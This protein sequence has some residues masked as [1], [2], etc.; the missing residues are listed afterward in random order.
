MSIQGEIR[1]ES[2]YGEHVAVATNSIAVSATQQSDTSNQS[3]N[4]ASGNLST[5]ATIIDLN[6]ERFTLE[7]ILQCNFD[8]V[9]FLV[10]G[11]IPDECISLIV[12]ESDL[13]KS[14]LHTQ[15]S[16]SIVSG[17][18]T[19]LGREINAKHQRVLI[20]STE[21]GIRGIGERIEKQ[22]KVI[23][24]DQDAA[25]RLIVLT[26]SSDI[27][28]KIKK[29]LRLNP[30]DLVI[31]DA[32]SDVYLG[33]MNISNKVRAFFNA[34]ADI[35][36]EFKCAIVFITHVGKSREGF[37]LH[38]NQVLG[39]V[40]IVDKARQVIMMSR[41]KYSSTNRQL[42]IIKA[43]YVSEEEK[44]KALI[45]KFNAEF[46]T[47]EVS[48]EKEV[49]NINKTPGDLIYQEFLA[50]VKRLRDQGLNYNKIGLAVNRHRSSI[51][52]IIEKHPEI[53]ENDP[54]DEL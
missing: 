31:V 52:R 20:V 29:E 28:N 36:R 18:N 24:P 5:D 4:I 14:T 10:E 30:V 43:N 48:E 17:C 25:K 46:R 8:K 44:K 3:S 16:L 47:F 50:E 6:R 42:T 39:S 22:C 32:F 34:Y 41:E 11:L 9:P 40:G 54:D 27:V 15:L 45:L 51:K 23:Q 2:S 1:N 33:D 38:K 53:F 26:S 21:E 13:G 49:K 35:I 37:S 7:E 19:F 12:G